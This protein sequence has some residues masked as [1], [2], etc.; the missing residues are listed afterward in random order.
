MVSGVSTADV[1]CVSRLG[2]G[3]SCELG[4]MNVIKQVEQAMVGSRY[5]GDNGRRTARFKMLWTEETVSL[6]GKGEMLE[7]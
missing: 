7:E 5:C 4:G 2:G 1:R 6:T 3:V